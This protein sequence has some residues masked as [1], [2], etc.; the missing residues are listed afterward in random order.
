MIRIS[1]L[2][3]DYGSH[4]GVFDVSLQIRT[5][6]IYGY[7]GPNGAGKSTTLRHIMGFCRPDAGTITV[8]GLDAWADQTRIKSIVGYLPG[9][10]ALPGDMKGLDY[11]KLMCRSI[12]FIWPELLHLF[13]GHFLQ[14]AFLDGVIQ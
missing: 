14:I 1:H 2:T 3:K 10:I 7:L 9:E 6:E 5:G 11:L 4:R 12:V 13:P 8:D